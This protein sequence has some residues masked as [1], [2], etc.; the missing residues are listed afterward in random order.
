MLEWTCAQDSDVR[1][2]NEWIDGWR[3]TIEKD[4]E[5]L[6]C[7]D[8]AC[9]TYQRDKM[10]GRGE[11]TMKRKEEVIEYLAEKKLGRYLK[12]HDIAENERLPV[13]KYFIEEKKFDPISEDSDRMNALHF[14]CK[15]NPNLDV[16]KYLIKEHKLRPKM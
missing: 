6:T 8:I 7:L 4:K 15:H 13:V 12:I 16:I 11:D 14:A 2:V 9:E 10:L 5:G 1:L 3:T